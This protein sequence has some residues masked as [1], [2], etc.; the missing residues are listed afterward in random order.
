MRFPARTSPPAALLH[1]RG[2]GRAQPGATT[3][4]RLAAADACAEPPPRPRTAARARA[5]TARSARDSSSL[6]A[7][8][9]PHSGAP[10]GLNWP[11]ERLLRVPRRV[12]GCSA[13]PCRQLRVLLLAAGHSASYELHAHARADRSGVKHAWSLCCASSKLSFC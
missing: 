1:A 8:N 6:H 11:R 4:A 7:P 3:R 9:R 2:Q 13:S 5:I 10:A 12:W